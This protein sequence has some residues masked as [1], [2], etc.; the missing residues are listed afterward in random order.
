MPF[1]DQGPGATEIRSQG[2]HV[3]SVASVT[4]A[5][6]HSLTLSPPFPSS[7]MSPPRHPCLSNTHTP[8]HLSNSL[9]SGSGSAP[10]PH[11]SAITPSLAFLFDQSVSPSFS[12]VVH[13]HCASA[14]GRTSLQSQASSMFSCSGIIPKGQAFRAQG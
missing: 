2:S 5:F 1:Y 13:C 14:A 8:A 4:L 10:T 11:H 9:P 12:A 7:S 6:S 3:L